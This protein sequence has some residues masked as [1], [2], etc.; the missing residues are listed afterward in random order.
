MITYS[1]IIL[2]LSIAICFIPPRNSVELMGVI[3]FYINNLLLGMII[4]SE[5]VLITF[6]CFVSFESG[7]FIVSFILSVLLLVY[8]YKKILENR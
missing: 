7:V 8:N 2:F 5:I 4:G 6:G 1:L 3:I